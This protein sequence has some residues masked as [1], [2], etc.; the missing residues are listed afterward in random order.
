[1][2]AKSQSKSSSGKS[3]RSNAS[4]G[5]DIK[6]KKKVTVEEDDPDD[7]TA[8][9][10]FKVLSEDQTKKLLTLE[11]EDI[12]KELGDIFKL[13]NYSTDLQ[14]ASTLDYYTGAVWWGK[15]QGLN[16]QQLSGLFTVVYNLFDNVK[17]QHM[18]KV[19][20]LKEFKAVMMGIEPEYPDVKSA[21]LD[22]FSVAQARAI[23]LY[24]HT[25]LFQHYNL[26]QFMFTHTQAEEI[27]GT[28]LSIEVAKPSTL[29][30]PPPLHEGVQD[31]M[32][33]SFIA[34]P[35][36]TPPPAEG[37]EDTK[38]DQEKPKE[39]EPTVPDIDAFNDLTVDDVREVIES[40]AKEMLG[41]LQND[42]AA[43]LRE[44]EN[45]IIQ[46]INKIHKVAE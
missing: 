31:D 6:G 36:P 5:K 11:V 19:D 29:P 40:V 34:T 26:Y 30:F 13:K 9:L 24:I 12:Q 33:A 22:F 8:V 37:A 32:Y 45:N 41:G 46:R 44:K 42:L 16:P 27:I 7:E 1:M 14:E 25:S 43:K 38:S 18:N 23:A 20:N 39:G 2:A 3:T 15:E 28:D 10:A 35:P 21:G 17:E 4:T